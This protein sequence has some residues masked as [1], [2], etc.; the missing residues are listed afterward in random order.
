ME[1]LSVDTSIGTGIGVDI[2]VVRDLKWNFVRWKAGGEGLQS[3]VYG[4]I[5]VK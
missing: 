5:E 3:R 2:D 4:I 1:S